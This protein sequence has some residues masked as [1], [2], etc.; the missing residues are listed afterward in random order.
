MLHAMREKK[1]S[2]PFLQLVGIVNNYSSH[3]LCLLSMRS[4]LMNGPTLDTNLYQ[5][6][7]LAD[8]PEQ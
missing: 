3:I 6:S 7:Y 4:R 1:K 5:F 2:R 8:H